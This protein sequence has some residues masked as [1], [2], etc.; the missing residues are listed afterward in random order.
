MTAR[1]CA[2]L[3]RKVG[4]DETQDF[5]LKRE[6]RV[7]FPYGEGS[8][9]YLSDMTPYPQDNEL[10]S[11]ACPPLRRHSFTTQPHLK[12]YGQNR[13]T[14]LGK[15]LA[16]SLSFKPSTPSIEEMSHIN[17]NAALFRE[18]QVFRDNNGSSI[19]PG[20][21]SP[22]ILNIYLYE[23]DKFVKNLIIENKFSNRPLR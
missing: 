23:L 17:T 11:G 15:P 9:I 8:E 12:F 10:G 2:P 22:L 1:L 14:E 18:A 6:K 7:T 4:I 5:A 16:E 3:C 19:I 21:I 13:R 20:I